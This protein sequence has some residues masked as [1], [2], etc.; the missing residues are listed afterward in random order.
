MGRPAP[1]P[2]EIE[3]MDDPAHPVQDLGELEPETAEELGLELE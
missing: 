2:Q 1:T 3:A